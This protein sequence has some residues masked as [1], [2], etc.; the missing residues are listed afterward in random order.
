MTTATISAPPM[1][2]TRSRSGRAFATRIDRTD[3]EI[4]S[5]AMI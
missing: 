2:I 5:A 1:M 3:Q 4:D